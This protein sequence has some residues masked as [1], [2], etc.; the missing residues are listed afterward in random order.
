M[1]SKAL[2]HPR[3]ARRKAD[4][5]PGTGSVVELSTE[6]FAGWHTWVETAGGATSEELPGS[7][8][9]QQGR[10]RNPEGCVQSR[11]GHPVVHGDPLLSQH[12]RPRLGRSEGGR[13]RGVVTT[14]AG[15][16]QS[17]APQASP[18]EDQAVGGGGPRAEPPVQLLRAGTSQG[19]GRAPGAERGQTEGGC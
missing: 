6:R 14:E 5:L 18:A 1:G 4:E 9:G 10:V 2:N 19:C 13:P 7:E 3:C 11:W 17:S 12:L 15:P 16:S 8:R